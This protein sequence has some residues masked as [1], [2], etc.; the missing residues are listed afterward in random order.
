[1]TAQLNNIAPRAAPA[2][3]REGWRRQ[4]QGD[5]CVKEE[6]EAGELV[7]IVV[8]PAGANAGE[9]IELHLVAAPETDATRAAAKRAEEDLA[10]IAALREE[11][12]FELARL[13]TEACLDDL[14]DVEGAQH[15]DVLSRAL[16]KYAYESNALSLLQP[17]A[18]T[19]SSVLGHRLRTLPEDHPHLQKARQNLAI[20]MGELGDLRG[21]RWL[22]EQVVAVRTRTLPEDHP[23]LQAANQNLA[24]TLF[25]LGDLPGAC[26]LF[27]QVFA[28]RSRTLPEDHPDLQKARLNLALVIKELGD[29]ARARA[30]E[31]SVLALLS[32]TQPECHPD[33]QT[34]RGNLAITLRALGD[35]PGSDSRNTS[36]GACTT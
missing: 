5:P 9:A 17:T 10:A 14:V 24:A 31:E 19:W 20:T 36:R 11:G 33:L 6:V 34:V 4:G 25:R 29:L 35:F 16:W 32:H 27:E 26:A 28:V 2:R 23:D 3:S 30:L 15:S 1:M 18:R 7:A 13:R 21:A 8:T 22:E 12:D